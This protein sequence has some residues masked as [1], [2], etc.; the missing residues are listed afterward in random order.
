[1]ITINSVNHL[2]N[3][4]QGY[5]TS[6]KPAFNGTTTVETQK[7]TNLL[8]IGVKVGLALAAAVGI[9]FA[10]RNGK[11]AKA[12]QS[13]KEETKHFMDLLNIANKEKQKLLSLSN[14]Y[15]D[16]AQK[17]VQELEEAMESNRK[18]QQVAQQSIDEAKEALEDAKNW[19]KL[20]EDIKNNKEN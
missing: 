18:L 15:Q 14:E 19:K 8:D 6:A 2:V 7:E 13:T 4:T 11:A 9:G 1:M 5:K 17:A 3:S 12:A 20:Y 16:I 10:I